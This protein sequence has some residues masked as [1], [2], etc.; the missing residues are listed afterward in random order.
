[1]KKDFNEVLVEIL[2]R[3]D[4]RAEYEKMGVQTEGN[5]NTAGWCVC[6]NPF[7][8]D[9]HASCGIN[10]GSG[11]HRGFFVA[12]NSMGKKGKPYLAL[13]FLDM[14]KD[15]LPGMCGDWKDALKHFATKTG[16]KLSGKK[17]KDNP[18]TLQM[19][20]S[21]MADLP[22]DAREY[23]NQKRGL[24][25]KSIEKYQIG[26]RK[27]DK[28]NTFPVYDFDGTLLN[29]RYHNSKKKPKT[30][31]HS[32]F[33]EARLWGV[34]R[35]TK[36]PDGT[37]IV[38]TEGEID[39]M[40]LE[41][42]IGLV[43]VSPTNGCNSF[44][45]SWVDY[46]KGKN[47]VLVWDCD[48]EGRKAVEK[49]VLPAFHKAV[50]SGDVLSLKIVWLFNGDAPKDQKDFTDYITKSGGTGAKLLKLI[51]N[52]L[53]HKFP[54]LTSKNESIDPDIFFDGNT[55]I[56]MEAVDY[57]M[58]IGDYFHDGMSFYQYN[59]KK[60]VWKE[61]HENIISKN[62]LDV[63]GKRTKKIYLGD[64][65]KILEVRTYRQPEKLKQNFYMINM[66]NGMLDLQEGK[67]LPHNKK[68]YSKIQIPIKFDSH[69]ECPKFDKTMLEMFPEDFGK[70]DA[71]QEFA[72]YC[73]YP[74]IF[75]EKCLFLIGEGSNGKSVFLYLLQ[76]IVG[77]E[78]ITSLDPQ[79]FS[80]KFLLGTIKDKLLNV[81]AEIETKEQ[82]AA[83]T[84]K[85]VVSGDL[86]QADEK[87]NKNPFKF[88]P[89]A[90]HVF[91]MNKVPLISDRSFAFNRRLL[92]VQFN[93]RFEDAKANKNLKYELA[94]TEL[95]G[96][97]NWAMLG[98]ERLLKQNYIIETKLMKKS[99]N[100]IFHQINP[101]LTFV[102]EMC[103]LGKENII[104]KMDLYKIYSEWCQESG[105]RKLGKIKFYNQL[106]SDFH[107]ITEQKIN[108]PWYFV[109]I[110][111][112]LIQC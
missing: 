47:V 85:K 89:I 51:Q 48:K 109:G 106:L 90:K 18:P 35:L 40:L 98:L 7:K 10:L 25:D 9:N 31:N 6:R 72:G 29:I 2:S 82:I 58:E 43:S 36:A 94:E 83:N 110:G 53:P 63:L 45:H 93:E 105:L 66:K 50:T 60:G 73:F 55:F 79:L 21:F 15:L 107:S 111:E 16:V 71:L 76:Q 28:R 23:L 54:K 69:A 77:E 12:F 95:S 49:I 17:K 101:V 103:K 33:G 39:S 52:T 81:S 14:A 91:S 104:K 65:L 44:S 75:I 80:D 26:F 42:E 38:I 32:G 30:L 11:S 1:M 57:L 84:F 3:L 78:N 64:T 4:I 27:S 24:T 59:E 62:I 112:N 102:D 34:D 41:Q 37:I 61:C 100:D 74:K 20:K 88:Y 87:Y 13:S 108:G 70:I 99:K 8:K 68:Y 5:P 22:Q 19:V 96:I 86:I 97:F 92:V 46:F 56:P 67:L